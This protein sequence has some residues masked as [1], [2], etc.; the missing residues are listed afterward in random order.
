MLVQCS[1]RASER[2]GELCERE[3]RGRGR[4][5][6]TCREE[7]VAKPTRGEKKDKGGRKG[8][9]SGRELRER[10]ER[11]GEP[12][13]LFLDLFSSFW[14]A[15]FGVLYGAETCDE[16]AVNAPPSIFCWFLW[17]GYW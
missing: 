2:E 9:N 17:A 4:G 3:I 15:M 11:R 10:E 8:K 6:D 5:P 1:G 14:S 13:Q 12:H 7:E 16:R